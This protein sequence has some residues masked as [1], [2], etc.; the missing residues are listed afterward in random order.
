MAAPR[1]KDRVVDMVSKVDHTDDSVVGSPDRQ[2]RVGRHRN[3]RLL[4]RVL[5]FPKPTHL[6]PLL[7]G[8][9]FIH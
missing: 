9:A 2:I 7:R 5:A 3:A 8:D 6:D 1:A 4:T